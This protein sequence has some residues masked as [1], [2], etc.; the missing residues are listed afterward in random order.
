MVRPEW[1]T[2]SAAVAKAAPELRAFRRGSKETKKALKNALDAPEAWPTAL[3]LS[4][5]V[6]ES[7]DDHARLP[8]S[9]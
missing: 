1:G 4:A 8:L 9:A 7:D 2:D 3:C 6:F 5:V